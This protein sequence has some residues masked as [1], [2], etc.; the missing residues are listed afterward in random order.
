MSPLK[1]ALIDR[2]IPETDWS[3]DDRVS[4]S[5]YDLNPD[6]PRTARSLT[7]A[8]VLVAVMDRP[9]GPTV[10]LTRRADTLARHTG[11]VALPGGRLEPGER[12]AEAALREAWE[13]VG[14]PPASVELLG[15]GDAYES[16]TGF[17]IT[18]AVGWVAAPPPLS[19]N[20]AEVADIFEAPWDFV[21]SAA[22]HQRDSLE[23]ATGP[24]RWFWSMTWEDYRIWGVTAG[25]LKSLSRRLDEAHAEDAP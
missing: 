4:K 6:L 7:P 22:N 8:A 15:L 2:L 12:A 11:Q 25:V 23:L 5:D 3:P 19:A 13:E 24:R 17:F 18:P 21:I 14:L 1:R 20:P 10:L 9:Q 16:A